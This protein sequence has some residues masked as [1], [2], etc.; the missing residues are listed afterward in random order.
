MSSAVLP[1]MYLRPQASS[2]VWQK[3]SLSFVDRHFLKT[4]LA[5]QLQK[6]ISH[7]VRHYFKLPRDPGPQPSCPHQPPATNAS[8]D[9]GRPGLGWPGLLLAPKERLRIM[10]LWHTSHHRLRLAI[11]ALTCVCEVAER[12]FTQ[13]CCASASPSNTNPDFKQLDCRIVQW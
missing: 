3:T 9:F 12:A 10:K 8:P 6:Q 5:A 11:S 7:S 1:N 2:H 13:P 4:T